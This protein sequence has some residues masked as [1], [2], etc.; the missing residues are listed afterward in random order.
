MLRGSRPSVVVGISG[1]GMEKENLIIK[2]TFHKGD[3]YQNFIVLAN[4]A[5]NNML[6]LVEYNLAK[7]VEKYLS[8]LVFV[9]KVHY[10]KSRLLIM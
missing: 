8:I 1:S 4:Q 5:H 2:I 3:S 9:N 10:A 7:S 6:I